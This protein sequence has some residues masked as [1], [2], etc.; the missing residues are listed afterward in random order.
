MKEGEGLR[1][2][3]IVKRQR[4][5]Q[6]EEKWERIGDSRFNRWYSGVKGKGVPNYL[7]KE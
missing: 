7:R 1:G 6:E 2:K 5:R 4:R 3:E